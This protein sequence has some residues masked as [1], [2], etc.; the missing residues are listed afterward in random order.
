MESC[1]EP[2]FVIE[3]SKK[4]FAFVL[5]KIISTKFAYYEK[6]HCSAWRSICLD[7]QCGIL[8]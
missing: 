8:M 7:L 1:E 6:K 5:W 2:G 3:E 4:D